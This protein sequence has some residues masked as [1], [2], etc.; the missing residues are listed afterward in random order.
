[1]N[2]RQGLFFAGVALVAVIPVMASPPP[3]AYGNYNGGCFTDDS[4][5]VSGGK[6]WKL[7]YSGSRGGDWKYKGLVKRINGEFVVITPDQSQ[8][9][10]LYW[11]TNLRK[12][13]CGR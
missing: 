5:Y 2:V 11:A 1:M 7:D 6:Y 13:I 4:I 12:D 9:P 3:G 10:K 8:P